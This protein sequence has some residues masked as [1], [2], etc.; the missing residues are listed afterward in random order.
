MRFLRSS[1]FNLFVPFARNDA[2]M[3]GNDENAKASTEL[4]KPPENTAMCAE[5][6]KPM[7]GKDMTAQTDARH[8]NWFF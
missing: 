2:E 5:A 1:S 7:S 3:I 6:D 4:N 8:E